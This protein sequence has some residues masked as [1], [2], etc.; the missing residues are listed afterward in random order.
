MMFKVIVF[1]YVLLAVLNVSKVLADEYVI[2]T[3]GAHSFINFKAS[4]LG[5]SWL[6]GRFNEFS[7][8]FSYDTNNVDASKIVVDINAASIDSNHAMRDKHLRA[9]GFLHSHKYPKATFVSSKVIEKDD[10][11][12]TIIG[13]FTLHGVTNQISINAKKVGEGEDPWGNDRVGFEGITAIDVAD[14]GFREKWV[15]VVQLELFVEGIRQ[16]E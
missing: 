3:K 13:D 2:D 8:K 14:F 9:K 4:H 6:T 16:G 7:G 15:G 11:Q 12:L 1:I 10:G 5:Y